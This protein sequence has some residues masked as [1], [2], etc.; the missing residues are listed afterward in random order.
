MEK[1]FEQAERV[2][3]ATLELAERTRAWPASDYDPERDEDLLAG[4][5]YRFVLRPRRVFKG[6][7]PARVEIRLNDGVQPVG[8][9]GLQLQEQTL[10]THLLMFE[11]HWSSPCSRSGA[12]DLLVDQKLLARL[13][14]LARLSGKRERMPGK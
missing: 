14:S 12:V 13:E 1:A 6:S 11:P 7:P 2:Y 3:L 8:A 10:G 5:D 9:R 4:D